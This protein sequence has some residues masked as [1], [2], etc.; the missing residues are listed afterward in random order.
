M[1]SSRL[2]VFVFTTNWHIDLN[3]CWPL[4]DNDHDVKPVLVAMVLGNTTSFPGQCGCCDER[5]RLEKSPTG[6]KSQREELATIT[7]FL[8]RLPLCD[9]QGLR[10][11]TQLLVTHKQLS[12]TTAKDMPSQQ[13]VIQGKRE[14]V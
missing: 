1:F 10:P 4:H 5:A 14:T 6:E 8:D 11:L 2:T 12:V 9:Y 7:L 13:N 3:T